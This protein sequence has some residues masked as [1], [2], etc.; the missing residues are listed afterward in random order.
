MAKQTNYLKL[1]LVEGVIENSQKLVKDWISDSN[2]NLTLIDAAVE[3]LFNGA[4]FHEIITGDGAEN[5]FTITHSKNR[6]TVSV[7]VFDNDTGKQVYPEITLIDY[8]SV[9]VTFLFPVPLGRKYDVII[10]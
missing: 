10:S 3:E 7:D 1:Q 9:T 5:V 4:V 2:I 8:N 6:L